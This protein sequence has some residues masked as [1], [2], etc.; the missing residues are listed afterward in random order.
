MTMIRKSLSAALAAA[1]LG[2]SAWAAT[3]DREP[4]HGAHQGG[5]A[6]AQQK[7][8][9][10]MALDLTTTRR[11]D[12]QALLKAWT[13]A[14]A[15]LAEGA[16]AAPLGTDPDAAPADAGDT[17]GLGPQRLTV[18]VGFGPGLFLKDGVDRYGLN[19]RRPAAFIDLP[20]FPG[21]QLIPE[22]T[23]GDL[24]VQ[25][26]SDDAEVS[27]HAA[28]QLARLAEPCAGVRWVQ[29]GFMPATPA[30]ATPR[31][32]MGFKDGTINVPTG[33]EAVM[34]QHVWVGPEGGWLKDGSYMVVRPIRIALEHWDQMKLGF[35]EEVV[36]RHKASG[37]PLG[38][39]RELDPLDFNA[40]G[41]DG[42]PVLP[43]TS[44]ARLTA[45]ENNQGARI[46]RRGYAYDNGIILATDRW[47][48]WHQGTRLDAGLL[49]V[50]FQRDPRTGFVQIFDKVAKFDMMNQFVTT[51]GGGLFACPAGSVGDEA[52]LGQ[53]LFEGQ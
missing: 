52:Y 3:P 41:P 25:I 12:V 40:T 14:S 23:G 46:L 20:H 45:P 26:C 7:H 32:L 27:L 47:P 1:L 53:A 17:V 44:H 21:D 5:I 49:F 11:E 38:G 48:P 6:T 8:I 16:P 42:N 15:R 28:R 31:N 4:F 51:T 39:T 19:A 30:G 37:A 22:R 29:T 24:A 9:Y 36:G 43:E 33:D 2:S 18:T 35:Q 50:C 13:R 10:F 34:A